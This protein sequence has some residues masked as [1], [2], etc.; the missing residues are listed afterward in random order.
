MA[1]CNFLPVF[2]FALNIVRMSRK[3]SSLKEKFTQRYKYFQKHESNLSFNLIRRN[4][5]RV[6]TVMHKKDKF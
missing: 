1:L 3:S 4:V 2:G 6:M 5:N